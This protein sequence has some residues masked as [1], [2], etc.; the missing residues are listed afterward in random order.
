[1]SNSSGVHIIK[2]VVSRIVVQILAFL[3]VPIIT[4][5]FLPEHFG[6]LQIF[7]SISTIAIVI[8]SLKYELSIPLARNDRE[9]SASFALSSLI[10]VSFSALLSLAILFGGQR[11]AYW[12]KLLELKSV[13]WWLLPLVVLAGGLKNVLEFWTVRERQ[14]GAIAWT[15]LSI[16]LMER[17]SH[18]LWGLLLGAS[19]AGLFTGRILGILL[20]AVLLF[21]INRSSFA[22]GLFRESFSFSTLQTT[23]IH[24]KKFPYFN[25]W[26]VF[27][28][29]LARQ[30]P[31]L[32]LG[33]Y[34]SNTVV[35][36]YALGYK[37]INTPI[38][39]LKQ[40]IIKVFF[41]LAAKEYHERESMT[42]IVKVFFTRLV[43]IGIFSM[44]LIAFAGPALFSRLFGPQW[45]E[46][47][48]YARI[49]SPW[50]AAMFVTLPQIFTIH[51]RQE[52]ALVMNI[53]S[54][55]IRAGGLAIGVS[56]SSP[57]TALGIFVA[58]SIATILVSLN[59]QFRLAKVSRLWALKTLTQY[60]CISAAL[61][62]PVL[63]F[64][65]TR[66]SWGGLISSLGLACVGYAGC[67]LYID[68]SFRQFLFDN[69]ARFRDIV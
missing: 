27:L 15:E 17:T 24:H 38:V 1:M 20:G 25:T 69:V 56:I 34:F 47:G 23:A 64:P 60:L 22:S 52:I 50:Y 33:T 45:Q 41:P 54:L 63:L 14:F 18:I 5:I 2:L 40:S 29:T 6:V 61:L 65:W 11:L 8:A 53:L 21:F 43:Q 58:V 37:V 46:A 39:M 4:R 67:L 66:E 42:E 30:L 49:L 35:G 3:T 48:M 10:V 7:D 12:L 57:R 26:N 44:A 9:A 31:P 13:L 59:W 16:F 32:I 51:Q 36:Y 62:C 68:P 55:F 28:N 19:V